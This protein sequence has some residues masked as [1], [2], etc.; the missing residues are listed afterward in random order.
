MVIFYGLNVQKG[1]A[2]FPPNTLKELLWVRKANPQK[3]CFVFS[4]FV[5]KRQKHSHVPK[6]LQ[7]CITGL[8][9]F[10]G[11]PSIVHGLLRHRQRELGQVGMALGNS[12]HAKLSNKAGYMQHRFF[13]HSWSKS[14]QFLLNPMIFLH[15][16]ILKFRIHSGSDFLPGFDRPYSR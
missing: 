8:R 11:H 7:V 3:P 13:P 5:G 15:I 14:W 1:V 9:M 16:D 2:F 12:Y 6:I 10:L 4:F